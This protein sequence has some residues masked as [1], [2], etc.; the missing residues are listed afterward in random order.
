MVPMD[1]WEWKPIQIYHFSFT[2]WKTSEK[3]PKIVRVFNFGGN[4]WHSFTEFLEVILKSAKHG[5]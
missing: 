4:V 1:I 2:H 5:R 3:N